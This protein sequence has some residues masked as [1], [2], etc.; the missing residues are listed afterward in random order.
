M[1]AQLARHNHHHQNAPVQHTQ[2]MNAPVT[3][4]QTMNA[5]APH[6]QKMNTAAPKTQNDHH[7]YAMM[8]GQSC[9]SSVNIDSPTCTAF[10]GIDDK[11]GTCSTLFDSA[12]FG[13]AQSLL[14]EGYKK[15]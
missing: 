11:S 10:C 15:A 2:Y 12:V 8:L 3:H 9:N 7:T 1:L 14:G 5:P 6:T 4:T 13:Y